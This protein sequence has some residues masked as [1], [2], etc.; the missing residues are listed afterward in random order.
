MAVLHFLVWGNSNLGLSAGSTEEIGMF[1]VT[2]DHIGSPLHT[3][4]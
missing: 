2:G 3:I 4:F 1:L